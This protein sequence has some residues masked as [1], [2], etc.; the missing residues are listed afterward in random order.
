[1]VMQFIINKFNFNNWQVISLVVLSFAALDFVSYFGW[2]APWFGNIAT[3]ALVLAWL[4]LAIKNLPLAVVYLV[5]ELV[6][7]SFGHLTEINFGSTEIS[8]RLGLFLAAFAIMLWQ[9]AHDRQHVIFKHLWRWWYLGALVVLLYAAAIGYYS[10]N[11]LGNLFLDANGYLYIL[12][13]PLFLQ[14]MAD[15]G[16][17]KIIYYGK[18]ILLPAI[19]WLTG[20]TLIL[21][22]AFTHFSADSLVWLYQWYRDTGLG[23]ITPAGGGFFRVFSQ[24]QIFSSLAAIIGLSYIWQT[25][26]SRASI[27]KPLTVFTLIALVT[28]IASLSRS[29]WL[30]AGIAFIIIPLVSSRINF[31][32]LGKYILVSLILFASAAGTVLA[33]SRLNWPV[34][35]LGA[36]SAKV[37]TDRFGSEPAGQAR[38]RLL[39]PLAEAIWQ[40]P[41]I[42]SGFGA[43]VLYYSTDPRAVAGSAGGT[44]FT[45]TYAF[46]WGWLDFLYKFGLLGFIIFTAWLAIPVVK[47]LRLWHQSS[48]VEAY[49]LALIALYLTHLT[50]PYLNHPLGLGAVMAMG[51]L[52]LWHQDN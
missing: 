41:I 12:I 40:K 18:L 52:I 15:A 16:R 19:I 30:G 36:S 51:S 27:F 33:V 50:T 8:L 38:L 10:W 2:L 23:E 7:G 26:K 17:E 49:S 3:I 46:E 1:M 45:N 42:G 28:L 25:I 47:G 35:S 22:Y 37:F 29:F 11:T 32:F 24:S 13:L 48:E 6:L 20:R 39:K 4:I 34:E 21:L 9:I 44:G 14:A 31:V 5:A 43:T